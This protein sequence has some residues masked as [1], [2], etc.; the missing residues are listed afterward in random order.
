MELEVLVPLTWTAKLTP[1]LAG[2][3]GAT[4][5]LARLRLPLQHNSSTSGPTKLPISQLSPAVGR[6]LGHS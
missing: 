5:E 2:E 6:V 3:A 4:R 1:A